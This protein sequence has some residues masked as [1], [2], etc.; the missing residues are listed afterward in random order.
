MPKCPL[1]NFEI[2]IFYYGDL[3]F[4]WEILGDFTIKDAEGASWKTTQ[5]MPQIKFNYG[6]K[7][8]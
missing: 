7:F 3:A 1:E 8:Y 4:I 6:L 2:K 5:L